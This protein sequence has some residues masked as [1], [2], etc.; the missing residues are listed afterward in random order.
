MPAS[1]VTV[2]TDP[3]GSPSTPPEPLLTSVLYVARRWP[4]LLLFM[5]AGACVL[6]AAAALR[7][8]Q[9]VA[10]AMFVPVS[11]SASSGVTSLAGSL[12]IGGFAAD[13]EGPQFYADLMHSPE[14]LLVPL[15]ERLPVGGPGVRGRTLIEIFGGDVSD[16]AVREEQALDYV[17]ARVV[18]PTLAPK[19][20]V[21]QVSVATPWAAVSQWLARRVLDQLD[22][23][24]IERRRTQ[25]GEER[26]F[27]EQL[28]QARRDSLRIA[29]N[30]LEAFVLANREYSNAPTL[31][32]AAERMRRD[33]TFQLS[34]LTSTTSQYEDA[35]LREVRDTPTITVIEPPRV[36]ARPVPKP[37]T[38]AAVFGA[39]LGLIASVLGILFVRAVAVQRALGDPEAEHLYRSV[40]VFRRGRR[41]RRAS[42]DLAAS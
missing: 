27:A 22:A 19:T 14:L 38:R 39:G 8:R 33:V 16:P 12:G 18:H 40:A 20:G 21:V 10:T 9:Y 3:A 25:A 34:L 29:E 2:P 26:R 11:R 23:F 36:P 37:V 17:A 24:N 5:I 42:G 1:L 15:K 30:R 41:T 4:V 31:T 6:G 7:P 35:R 28:L 13:A 32:L